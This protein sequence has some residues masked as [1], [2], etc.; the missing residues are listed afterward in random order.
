MQACGSSP[1]WEIHQCKISPGQD[2]LPLGWEQTLGRRL[3]GA[4]LTLVEIGEDVMHLELGSGR[5]HLGVAI[6]ETAAA[7]DRIVGLQVK[8]PRATSAMEAGHA[9]QGHVNETGRGGARVS[10]LDQ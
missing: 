3:Q 9:H 10:H 1:Q 6:A 8:S 4:P 2:H 7:A 5:A